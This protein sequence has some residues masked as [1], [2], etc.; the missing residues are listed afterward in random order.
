M[1]RRTFLKSAAGL[2]AFAIS[3]ISIGSQPDMPAEAVPSVED[4]VLTLTGRA[5]FIYHRVLPE[6][7]LDQCDEDVIADG[8]INMWNREEL[9]FADY[10]RARGVGQRALRRASRRNST[11]PNK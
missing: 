6:L 10:R 1:D 9:A 7:D 11:K 2:S 5:E 4:A 3:G 8:I